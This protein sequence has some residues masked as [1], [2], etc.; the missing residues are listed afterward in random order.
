[1]N[2]EQRY[3]GYIG[4]MIGV[5]IPLLI[6]ALAG[7]STTKVNRGGEVPLDVSHTTFLIKTE[8]PSLEAERKDDNAYRASFNAESRG[9]DVEAM[10]KIFDMF[11]Y[12]MDRAMNPVPV[13]GG[14]Q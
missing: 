10:A 5:L 9:G 13:P 8:A 7:C 14:D 6:L 11:M 3:I 12:M 4:L 2:R 1:M